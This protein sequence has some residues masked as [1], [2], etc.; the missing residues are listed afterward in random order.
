MHDGLI[1]SR[2]ISAAS[3]TSVFL[4]IS[5]SVD[6]DPESAQALGIVETFS[7]AAISRGRRRRREG[8]RGDALPDPP[9]DGHRGKGFL[10]M[11]GELRRRRLAAGVSEA[12]AQIAWLRRMPSA[13]VV[14][15]CSLRPRLFQRAL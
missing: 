6:I 1:E 3:H 2:V 9:G 14:I 4:A 5:Q 15:P 11:T 7:A 13:S 12:A 10:L 8:G